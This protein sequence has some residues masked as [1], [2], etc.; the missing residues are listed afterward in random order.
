MA[1]PKVIVFTCN[2]G[3]YSSLEAAG[4]EHLEYSSAIQPLRVNCL[5]QV[6]PGVILK[7]FEKGADGVLMLGCPKG[8]CHYEFGS[9]HAEE[10]FVDAKALAGMLGYRDEQLQLDWMPAAEA[11]I[12]VEKVQHFLARLMENQPI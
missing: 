3:A 6:S 8:E 1:L 10:T 2:W 5:G 7:A 9:R 12:F 4:K 11:H